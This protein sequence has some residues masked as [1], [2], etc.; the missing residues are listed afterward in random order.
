MTA[1]CIPAAPAQAPAA[2]C[3]LCGQ[4]A[5]HGPHCPGCAGRIRHTAAALAGLGTDPGRL[6]RALDLIADGAII[7]APTPG[8][9]TSISSTGATTYLTTPSTC[10]CPAGTSCYHTLAAI[11]LTAAHAQAQPLPRT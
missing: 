11:I 2:N 3:L 6:A 9:W 7:P 1:T 10:T 5:T 8:T 4:P